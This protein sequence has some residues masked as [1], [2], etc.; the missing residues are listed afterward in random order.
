VSELL[1]PSAV[2]LLLIL[3]SAVFVAAEFAIVGAPRAWIE[4]EASQGSRLAQRVARILEDP[5]RQDRYIATT[6]VG[7]SAESLVIGMY[8]E[9]KLA[10][11][12][13]ERLT[14]L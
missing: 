3:A 7:I 1:F 9:Q 13:A 6:Q 5:K 12:L 11:L 2:I 4:H 10:A 8:G 14:V